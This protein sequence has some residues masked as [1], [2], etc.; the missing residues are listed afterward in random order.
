MGYREITSAFTTPVGSTLQGVPPQIKQ[1]RP[2]QIKQGMPPP[3][4]VGRAAQKSWARQPEKRGTP[5]KKADVKNAS[6]KLHP[7]ALVAWATRRTKRI[8]LFFG[9]AHGN[10]GKT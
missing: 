6:P 5:P 7:R 3:K 1:G 10:E 2:L 4:K 8:P 9:C